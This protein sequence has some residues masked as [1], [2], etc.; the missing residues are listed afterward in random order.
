MLVVITY[1][2]AVIW[3]HIFKFEEDLEVTEDNFLWTFDLENES[4]SY[5]L[6]TLNY[7]VF[8]TLTT[9]GFGDLHPR[10]DPERVFGIMV[11]L[12]GVMI[13]SFVLGNFQEGLLQIEELNKPFG[14]EDQLSLFLAT[15][16]RFNHDTPLSQTAQ[17]DLA[18][19]FAYRWQEDKN[20][21]VSSEDDLKLLEQMPS[22]VQTSI[23][24]EFL[25]KNFLDTHQSCLLNLCE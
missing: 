23:Y 9:V 3:L 18:K 1:F 17:S 21:I 10:S 13:T 19:F 6:I 20:V 5:K 24:S 2:V 12:F 14:D 4:R 25:F 16:K 22:D 15:L 8:T 11:F 7:F